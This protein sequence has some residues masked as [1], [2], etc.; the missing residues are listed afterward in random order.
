M[1]CENNKCDKD[2]DGL[3]GDYTNNK[4]ENLSLLC[5]NCH[6]LTDNYRARGNNNKRLHR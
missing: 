2:H 3:Y 1:K 6:S 4:E 5:P